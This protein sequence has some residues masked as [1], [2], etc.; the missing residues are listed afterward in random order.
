MLVSNH[1]SP[2]DPLLVRRAVAIGRNKSDAARLVFLPASKGPEYLR[3]EI[4]EVARAGLRDGR[5]VCLFAEGAIP[6][7]GKLLR[8]TPVIESMVRDLPA[9]II[10]VAIDRLWGPLAQERGE[11]VHWKWPRPFPY[12]VTVTFGKPLQKTASPY[13]IRRSVQ[14]LQA[15]LFA[16][17]KKPGETLP[18]KFVRAARRFPFRL[19]MV[20]HTG[21]RLNFLKSLAGAL[22]LQ[23][24]LRPHL[25][26]EERVGVLL[27]PS[28]GAALTNVALSFLGK[29]A[30]NLNYAWSRQTYESCLAKAKLRKVVTSAQFLDKLGWENREEFLELESLKSSVSLGHRL[31]AFL[32]SAFLPSSLLAR[33][34][35]LPDDPDAPVTVLFSSGSTGE[36]KGIV[37]SHFNIL[38]N[39]QALNQTIQL[40]P[41]DRLVGVLPFF[42]SFG[43]SMT[44]WFPLASGNSALYHPDPRDGRAVAKLVREL[45]GTILVGPPTF[46]H[47]YLRQCEPDDFR[48][49]RYAVAGAEKLKPTLAREFRE[50][51]GLPL[52]EGYGATELSPVVSLN[53]FDY[54][55]GTEFER[56]HKE[57][58]IGHPIPGVVVK[59]VGIE[60]GKELEAGEEGLLCV[61]GPNVMLGYLDDPKG[62]AEVIQDGWYRTGDVGRI[63]EDG[64][65]TITDRLSRFSKIGGEMV[66][67]IK[68]ES[69]LQSEAPSVSFAVASLPDDRKGERLAVL[70]TAV[71]DGVSPSALCAALR[72]RGLSNLAVPKPGCFVEVDEIPSLA[73]GKLDLQAVREIACSRPR[74]KDSE[75]LHKD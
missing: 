29:V 57:G 35:K 71:P 20:D 30:V 74:H 46:F 21:R 73:S 43:Y 25:Q 70:H 72:R 55:F 40:G 58:T 60:T 54:P 51:F 63:D 27:P 36:P 75:G 22:V 41:K 44:L 6:R 5:L 61:K 52:L 26:G 14:E 10:P 28:I 7:S 1:V 67:H 33:V 31:R 19:A 8:F 56:G 16:Q 38:S 18:R 64:F 69:E 53:T 3:Q 48:N 34:Y 65:I 42:H 12:P 45:G 2:V 13:R 15:S 11:E 23:R 37:L 47:I 59:V 62:T 17:R 66:P 68:V 49:L 9:V 32:A 39:I 4:V 24:M 50:R